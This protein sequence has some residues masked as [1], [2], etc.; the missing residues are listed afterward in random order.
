MLTFD[1]HIIFTMLKM[2][3]RHITSTCEVEYT[4]HQFKHVKTK[5]E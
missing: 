1:F 5:N 2:Y 3:A 4:R